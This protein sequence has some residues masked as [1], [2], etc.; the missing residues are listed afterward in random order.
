MDKTYETDRVTPATEAAADR[1]TAR[2]TTRSFEE[3]AARFLE[4]VYKVAWWKQLIGSLSVAAVLVGLGMA[5]RLIAPTPLALALAV[6]AAM[7]AAAMVL[8]RRGAFRQMRDADWSTAEHYW[9]R[10]AHQVPT[11]HGA[12][13]ARAISGTLARHPAVQGIHPFL[14]PCPGEVPD[15]SC[16]H[17]ECATVAVATAAA[18]HRVVFIGRRSFRMP[19]EAFAAVVWH[20]MRH[21]AGAM[22]GYGVAQIALRFAGW[23]AVGYL[24]LGWPSAIAVWLALGAIAWVNELIC[25]TSG[26][27]ATSGA[28]I[29]LAL[30]W[31]AAAMRSAP[32]GVRLRHLLVGVLVPSHPPC[33][34]RSLVARVLVP[35]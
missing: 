3:S 21:A 31:K 15:G 32:L 20:E 28:A 2:A 18:G 17:R 7:A 13:L 24:S 9:S 8:V 11:S 14:M 26:G 23:F 35:R 22:L 6:C 19:T 30:D 27:R 10:V 1:D 4:P 29:C 16:H 5:A 12:V 34:A 25:D 33:W